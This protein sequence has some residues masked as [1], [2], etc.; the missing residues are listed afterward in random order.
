MTKKVCCMKEKHLL[1]ITKKKIIIDDV[2][3]LISVPYNPEKEEVIISGL[4]GIVRDK[5]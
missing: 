2:P 4:T 1:K 5:S 3:S